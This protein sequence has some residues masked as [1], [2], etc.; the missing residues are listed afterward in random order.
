MIGYAVKYKDAINGFTI[1]QDKSFTILL[2]INYAE[3][4]RYAPDGDYDKQRENQWR[5][6]KRRGA[7]IVKVRITEI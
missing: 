3:E 5:K 2:F 4:P 1:S 7:K 6:W